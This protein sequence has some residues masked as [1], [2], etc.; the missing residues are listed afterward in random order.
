MARARSRPRDYSNWQNKAIL[1]NVE[2]TE[3]SAALRKVPCR[4]PAGQ[5]WRRWRM[6]LQSRQLRGRSEIG[7]QLHFE[8]RWARGFRLFPQWVRN[9]QRR[10]RVRRLR[11]I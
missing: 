5:D 6:E 3:P 2:S 8:P 7:G 4:E 1:R 10:E 9:E 11:V